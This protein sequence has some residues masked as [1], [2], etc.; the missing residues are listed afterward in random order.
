MPQDKAHTDT[1]I[2]IPEWELHQMHDEDIA[3]ALDESRSSI[4][5]FNGKEFWAISKSMGHTSFDF[6]KCACKYLK[7]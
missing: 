5:K 1:C 4:R 3:V 7:K 6:H 2:N